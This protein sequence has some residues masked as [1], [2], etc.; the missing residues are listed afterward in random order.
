MLK[1]F[2]KTKQN[3]QGHNIFIKTF[4]YMMDMCMNKICFAFYKYYVAVKLQLP[5]PCLE[6]SCPLC[7]PASAP[8][9]HIKW[10]TTSITPLPFIYEVSE[11]PSRSALRTT[12]GHK[13]KVMMIA[14]PARLTHHSL[15][16]VTSQRNSR[17]MTEVSFG[18]IWLNRI[19]H[20]YQEL[21][22]IAPY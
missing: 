15:E 5:L 19:C 9:L 14:H 13:K 12:M 18:D 1:Q 10:Q 3:T 21:F 11:C 4:L 16:R 20:C 8:T 2:F 22:S 6:R 7:C 17:L